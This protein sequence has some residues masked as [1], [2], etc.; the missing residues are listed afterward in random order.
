MG[1]SRPACRAAAERVTPSTEKLAW[2]LALAACLAL[3]LVP[4]W[5]ARF[6]AMQD[7]PGQLLYAEVLR[8]HGDP[9]S[10]Y[11]RY[12][13]FRFSPVYATFYAA[14]IAFARVVPIETAGKLALSLVPI[15]V[16]A[17]ALRLARRLAN[18]FAPWGAL[19]LFP[20]AFNQ[21]WFYGNLN[22]VLSLPMLLLALLDLEDLLSRPLGAWPIARHVLWQAALFATHPLTYLL[23]VGLGIAAALVTMHRPNRA[24]RKLGIVCG[25]AVVFVACLSFAGSGGGTAGAPSA[26]GEDWLSPRAT[27][28]FLGL[29][30]GGM[31]PLREARAAPLLL[32]GAILVVLVL[33]VALGRRRKALVLL[34]MEHALLL[35]LAVLAT[36]V[37]PFRVGDYSY[38]NVRFSALAYFLLALCAAHVRFGPRLG[39]CLA[40]LAVLCLA[41][42]A[43]MQRRISAEAAEILP[44]AERIPAHARVLPLV[45]DP[46]SPELD[47]RWF[48]PHVQEYNYVPL[49][50]GGGFNPYLFGSPLDPVRPKPGQE[51]PAPPVG[52]PDEF[53]WERHAADYGYILV[54]GAPPGLEQYL[55]LHS[56]RVAASGKWTLYE[57]R[58]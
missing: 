5:S 36:F 23:F 34:P 45:F 1:R 32:W 46:R 53:R 57:R 12:Y 20:F 7:Y 11:D 56:Q 58:R 10:E 43:A 40:S 50:A 17:V 19:L 13:D 6:P 49:I 39:A 42:S 30:F 22:Y 4:I 15:L 47:S 55:E 51:R 44:V 52:R 25:M 41:D 31:Q 37:L 8:S 54:L 48:A 26:R 35:A 21:Q 28:S 24:W 29:M 38:L 27:L 3:A 14:T 16:A 9:A 33:S 2:R 18:D